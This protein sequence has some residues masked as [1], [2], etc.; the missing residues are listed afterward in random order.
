[1]SKLRS[2]IQVVLVCP[3]FPENI[4][5]AARAC[6]NMGVANLA[7]VS[8]EL[9][10][11]HYLAEHTDVSDPYLE[12]AF[13]LATSAGREII[14][15][16]QVYDGLAQALAERT[17]SIGATARTGGW[18]QGILNPAQAAE[19]ALAHL[20]EGGKVSFVFGPEDKG[21]DNEAVELCSH[22]VTIPT[23]SEPSLNLAQAVLLLL[24]EL[25]RVLP[26]DSTEKPPH[27]SGRAGRAKHSPPI[28]IAQ[29]ELLIEKLKEAMLAL[30]SLPADNSSYFMLPIRR[31]VTR[32]HIRHNEFSMLMGI[33]GK[34]L[35]MA[36][37]ARTD[38]PQN[39]GGPGN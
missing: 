15:S 24:Y 13:S 16:L 25:S 9:W 32:S 14:R 20:E 19:L 18:R 29:Q 33:C 21:L 27:R 7:L 34:I 8:P 28:T 4:G 17:L 26:F 5:M 22:L 23:A 10:P 11:D 3:R 38:E 37:M 2:N 30:D 35:R 39:R 31:L 6:G 1:M 12:K 36:G